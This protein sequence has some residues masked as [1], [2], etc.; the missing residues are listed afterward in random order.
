MK[1]EK[2]RI[3]VNKNDKIWHKHYP[4]NVTVNRNIVPF[5]RKKVIV[6][7]KVLTVP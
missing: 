3:F 7:I 6:I 2:K 5:R 4:I 1:I